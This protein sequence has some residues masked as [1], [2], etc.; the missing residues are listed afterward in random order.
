VDDATANG[1][2][3]YDDRTIGR[4]LR[5]I[6]QSR[7]LSLTVVAGLAGTSASTLSRIE[8]GILALDS[9]KLQV[10]L[11]NALRVA[12]SDLTSLPIPAPA[13]GDTDI[14]I[15]AIRH[16]LMA[17]TVGRPG[18]Q[19]QP[20]AQLRHRA[21]EV[22]RTDYRQRDALYPALIADLYT[23][24]GQGRISSTDHAALLCTAIMLHARSLGDFLAIVGAPLDL[25]WQVSELARDA[26]SDLDDAM[27]SGVVAWSTVLIMLNGGVFDLASREL[28]ATTVPTDTNEGLQLDG[29]LALARSLVAASTN[30][31]A[32]VSASLHHATEVAERTGQGD[33]FRLGFGPVNVGLWK[34][35]VALES[36]EPDETVRVAE[37]LRPAEHPSRER[38]AAYWMDYGRALAR[39]RRRDDAAR[40]L[41]RAEALF[42]MRALRNPFTRDTLA[43]L[44]AHS[45]DDALGRQ[46]RS[47][48]YRAGLPV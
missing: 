9:R 7:K 17:V 8:N 44:V 20:V 18:G 27:M 29:M 35:A 36:G 24:L 46:V 1:N 19:M 41:L 42:S 10:A 23:T 45:K 12:P 37:G 15:D 21:A 47:M 40:S 43:E 39:V 16:V 26:A 14:A 25:R 6:R 4:R 5:H 33:A 31:P 2:G 38:R 3:G 13:N 32:E 48:A 30:R 11:A 28:D 22:D 34:M